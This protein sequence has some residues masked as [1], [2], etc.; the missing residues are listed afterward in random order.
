MQGARGNSSS[1]VAM[2]GRRR[3]WT[4]CVLLAVDPAGLAIRA[5]PM[6]LN[7]WKS[8]QL[9]AQQKPPRWCLMELSAEVRPLVFLSLQY[10]Q[11]DPAM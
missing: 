3:G 6:L 9:K 5:L 4:P 1:E 10:P 11:G 2:L 8:R 7:I